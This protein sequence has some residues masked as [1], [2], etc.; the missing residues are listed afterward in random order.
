MAK[1]VSNLAILYVS[2]MVQEMETKFTVET[3]KAPGSHHTVQYGNP[4][5]LHLN[6]IT[7]VPSIKDLK[8]GLSFAQECPNCSCGCDCG[9]TA[10][11]EG[12]EEEAEEIVKSER[13]MKKMIEKKEEKDN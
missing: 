13:S 8:K 6:R 3:I 2:S 9:C 1:A 5:K 10:P 4:I 12:D 11:A 7:S